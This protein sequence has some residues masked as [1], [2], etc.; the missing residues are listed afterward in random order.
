ML[1]HDLGWFCALALL[2]ALALAFLARSGGLV[3]YASC[4]WCAV[5]RWTGSYGLAVF[6][7]SRA[8]AF[9]ADPSYPA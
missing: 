2:L 3:V 4:H 6:H 1:F 9:A 8:A 5:F 7:V